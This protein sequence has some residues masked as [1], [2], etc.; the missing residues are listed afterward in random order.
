MKRRQYTAEYVAA[1][2]ALAEEKGSV[3]AAAKELGIHEGALYKWRRLKKKAAP[4][5]TPK[6]KAKANGNGNGSHDAIVYLRH[7]RDSIVED[8][9]KGN[10]GD[11]SFDFIFAMLVL[12]LRSL[13]GKATK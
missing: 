9:A 7:A 13:E 3:P 8:V 4:A 6:T 2:L 10:K 12:A 5:A 1:A 11:G